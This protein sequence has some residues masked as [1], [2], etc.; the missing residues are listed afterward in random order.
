MR[1]PIVMATLA[2]GLTMALG[3]GA[4]A[5]LS[6]ASD[7]SEPASD[8]AETLTLSMGPPRIRHDIIDV[9]ATF[10]PLNGAA[11]RTLLISLLDGEEVKVVIPHFPEQRFVFSRSGNVVT[12]QSEATGVLGALAS[13][14]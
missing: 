4:T 14:D 12:A 5:T 7:L 13:T 11:P 8:T 3:A 6:A 9:A 1:R 2:L 10:R